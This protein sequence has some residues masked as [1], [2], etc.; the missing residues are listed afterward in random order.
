MFPASGRVPSRSSCVHFA[1]RFSTPLAEL[2]DKV[3]KVGCGHLQIMLCPF[4]HIQQMLG[5]GRTRDGT[6]LRGACLLERGG[7]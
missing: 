7:N 1:R 2:F 6:H 3:M 5:L 4:L